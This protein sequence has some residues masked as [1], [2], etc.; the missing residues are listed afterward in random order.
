MFIITC[1]ID[2]D[3]GPTELMVDNADSLITVANFLENKKVVF[4]VASSVE[5]VKPESYGWENLKQWKYWRTNLYEGIG[6]R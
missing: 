2:N 3:R 6:G 4:K 5:S 1:K